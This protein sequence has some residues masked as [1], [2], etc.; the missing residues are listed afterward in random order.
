MLHPRRLTP[1]SSPPCLRAP[2]LGLLPAG[3]IPCRIQS[4]AARSQR[5]R[6]RLS[7]TSAAVGQFATE[8][9]FIVPT[10]AAPADPTRAAS[11]DPA[12]PAPADSESAAAVSGV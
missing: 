2:G 5:D 4:A 8:A 11:A 7:G 12:A 9:R 1:I 6:A 10:R 3:R